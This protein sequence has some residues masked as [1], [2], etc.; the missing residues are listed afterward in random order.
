MQS[1][2]F[3]LW[4]QISGSKNNPEISTTTTKVSEFLKCGYSMFTTC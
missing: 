2:I 4:F 1:W 3:D